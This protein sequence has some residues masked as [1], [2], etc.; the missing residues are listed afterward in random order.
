MI[1]TFIVFL[2]VCPEMKMQTRNGPQQNP[3]KCATLFDIKKLLFSLAQLYII[4][5]RLHN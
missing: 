4:T 1:N 2:Q 3:L 5:I